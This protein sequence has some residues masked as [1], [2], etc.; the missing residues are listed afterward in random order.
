M[1]QFKYGKFEVELDFTDAD[2][3]DKIDDAYEKI[4]KEAKELPAAGKNSEIV[5]AQIACYDRFFDRV[6]GD[7][8]SREMFDANSLLKRIEAA[9]E[10]AK[11]REAEDHKFNDRLNGYR[12]NKQWNREQRRNNQKNH[13]KR[14]NYK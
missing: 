10:L 1:S 6:F 4:Q 5:R 11:F 7:G 8:A 13:N 9:E 3:L 14:R 2:L 12:V